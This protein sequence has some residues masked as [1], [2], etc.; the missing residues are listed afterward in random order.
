MV[1]DN[2]KSQN[3]IEPF[4]LLAKNA[5]GAAATHLIK[6][7]TEAPG[8]YVFGEL[9]QVTNINQLEKDSPQDWRLL[10]L[11]SFGTYQDYLRNTNDY[12]TLTDRQVL[13]LRYLTIVTLASKCHHVPYSVLQEELQIENLRPLEDLIIDAIYAGILRG[14]LNQSQQQLE[15]DFVIGRDMQSETIDSIIQTLEAW[16]EQCT[17]TLT[18]LETQIIRANEIKEMKSAMK[19]QTDVEIENVKKA[20]KAQTQEMSQDD[21]E[22]SSSVPQV[23]PSSSKMKGFKGVK[24]AVSAPGPSRTR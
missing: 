10:Q 8:V 5:R 12:P 13:K 11:F 1:E 6:Q 15:V 16:S 22:A 21:L 3:P 4:L 24:A 20:L 14:K 17:S 9:A 19:K 18:S 2:Y 23:K 7:A